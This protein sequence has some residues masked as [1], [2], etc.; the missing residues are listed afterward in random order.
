MIPPWVPSP[1]PLRVVEVAACPWPTTQGTQVHLRGLVRALTRRGHDVHLVTYHFGED[2]PDEGATVHRIPPVPGYRKLRAGPSIAK[3][4][5]DGL[6]LARLAQ[7]VHKTRPDVLHVHNYEAPWAGYAVRAL[8]GVPVVYT[9]HNL[10]IDELDRYLQG[11]LLRAGARGLAGWL[12]RRVPRMADRCVALSDAALPALIELGVS[13]DRLSSLPPAV[14]LEDLGDEPPSAALSAPLVLYAGNPDRYQ[15]LG[16]LF[17]AMVLVR[18]HRPDAVLRVVSGADL[19]PAQAQAR[20]LGLGE[21]VV[22]RRTSSWAEVRAEI[23]QARVAAL[24]RGLC[25]GAPI[26]RLNFAGLA[27]PM[28]AC[29]GSAHGMGDDAGL[30]VPDGDVSGFAV[31]LLRLLEDPSLAG[32]MGTAA[33]ASIL[34][35]STWQ[36]RVE[37]LESEFVRAIDACSA[38]GSTVDAGPS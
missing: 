9:A 3:P 19:G 13:A 28:V 37:R 14:H 5:L 38:R 25:R 8:S 18:R 23:V 27:R 22:F 36:H 26:K 24:P 21:G 33:R 32:R 1:R 2:L 30:R 6:L 35:D 11:R 34:R 29:E 16:L 7:V 31:A 15:D 10:M 4:L 17:A 20:G 12:D